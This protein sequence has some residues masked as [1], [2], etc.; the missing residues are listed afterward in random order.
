MSASPI[1]V[2]QGPRLV[3]LAS[4]AALVLLTLG[5]E[6]WW[7]PLRP[8]G[9]WLAL[10][11]L[12]LAIALPALYRGST[13]A[14]KWWSMLILAYVCEGA[15]RV[16]SDRGLSATLAAIELALATLAFLA[17]LQFMRQLRQKAAPVPMARPPS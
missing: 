1:V 3:V 16:V 15:V 17:I 9:S 10:K 13:Q 5:W 7:A 6:L 14:F 11:A 4:C 12:P 2:P 8:G